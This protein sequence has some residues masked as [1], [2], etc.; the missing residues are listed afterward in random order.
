MPR[1]TKCA[2]LGGMDPADS[3]VT[4]LIAPN[5]T[6]IVHGR[7]VGDSHC[8]T[9]I[10]SQVHSLKPQN[11]EKKQRRDIHRRSASARGG[12]RIVVAIRGEVGQD[13]PPL[14]QT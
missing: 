13:T 2:L 1:S 3:R 9:V 14:C 5:I 10:D 4:V 7:I 12:E 8:I 6:G 11:E